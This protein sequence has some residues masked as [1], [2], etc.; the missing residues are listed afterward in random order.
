[1]GF[2]GVI[3]PVRRIGVITPFLAGR[4]PTLYIY[5]KQDAIVTY[6][7]SEYSLEDLLVPTV[8]VNLYLL[9]LLG[10]GR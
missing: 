5:P 6:F 9:V 7:C 3:S 8:L 10:L 1:M 2:T 4:G